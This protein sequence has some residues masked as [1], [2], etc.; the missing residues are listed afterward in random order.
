MNGNDLDVLIVRLR[1]YLREDVPSGIAH[2]AL[3]QAEREIPH[4]MAGDGGWLVERAAH[5]ISSM[6]NPPSATTV[7][8]YY[9]RP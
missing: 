1:E 4:Y 2:L 5:L 6:A 8:E 3:A 7:T 9:D